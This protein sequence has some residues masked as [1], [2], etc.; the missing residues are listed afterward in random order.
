MDC[1]HIMWRRLNNERYVCSTCK[2][3]T[4]N[5]AHYKRHIE[6]SKHFLLTDLRFECPRDLKILIASF[7]PIYKI[8]KLK[9]AEYALR[10]AWSQDHLLQY[11]PV[12]RERPARIVNPPVQTGGGVAWIFHI[13]QTPI[14]V[15]ESF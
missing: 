2:Y 11:L 7:L 1:A 3:K 5:L 9:F 14:Y 13:S 6:S 12:G 10:L 15:E 4:Y 8:H